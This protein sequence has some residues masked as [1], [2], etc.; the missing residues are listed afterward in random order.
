MRKSWKSVTALACL[1]ALAAVLAAISLRCEPVYGGHTLSY[2]L[3]VY[4]CGFYGWKSPEGEVT[5]FRREEAANAVRQ[6]GSKALPYLCKWINYEPSRLKGQVV[7]LASS[8]GLRTITSQLPICIDQDA[9]A[10]R[11]E[12]AQLG[13]GILG[14]AA[15]SAIPELSRL[16]VSLRDPRSAQRAF[17]ALCSTGPAAAPAIIGMMTNNSCVVRHEA[18][19]ALTM[20]GTNSALA[21][22]ALLYN[23]EDPDE[24]IV[25]ASLVALGGNAPPAEQAV[26]SL[27]KFLEHPDPLLRG[28]AADCLGALGKEA[29]AATPVLKA[30]M[31]DPDESV[32]ASITNA[33]N[34]IDPEALM[35]APIR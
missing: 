15:Q 4:A 2:W 14:P 26:P 7:R 25:Y 33:L 8:P 16:A 12:T 24:S 5:A 34:V 6:I 30:A 19:L 3:S 31:A 1:G 18:V 13:F 35:N 20:L 22:P 29:R 10:I 9:D 27:T 32:R 23:L 28:A 21:N 17:Q 11:A